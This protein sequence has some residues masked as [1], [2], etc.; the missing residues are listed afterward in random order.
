MKAE[1]VAVPL[2]PLFCIPPCADVLG[3]HGAVS[4]PGAGWWL[5]LKAPLL[6][7]VSLREAQPGPRLGVALAKTV[8]I[9]S[10]PSCGSSASITDVTGTCRRRKLLEAA[11]ESVMSVSPTQPGCVLPGQLLAS[12][13]QAPDPACSVGGE[14]LVPADTSKRHRGQTP[15]L[16]LALPQDPWWQT[17]PAWCGTLA[18]MGMGSCRRAP[19][20]SSAS[21]WA[22]LCR[23]CHRRLRA[24]EE[25]S[26]G[27]SQ[28]HRIIS[29]G[30]S[31]NHVGWKGL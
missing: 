14:E 4:G 5:C 29:V 16:F 9:V 12:T 2:C 22:G 23:F 8:S 21:S 20:H 11:A 24:P 6:S 17:P 18:V 3:S 31:R 1:E 7:R 28:K 27:I 25:G 26:C 15:F 13:T 30:I 10:L 19:H